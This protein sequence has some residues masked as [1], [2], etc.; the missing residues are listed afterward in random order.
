MLELGDGPATIGHPQCRRV[1]MVMQNLVEDT[2]LCLCTDSVLKQPWGVTYANSLRV[3]NAEL[4]STSAKL[5]ANRDGEMTSNGMA[6]SQLYHTGQLV[7]HPI[8]V[9][10]SI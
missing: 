8:T 10:L 5:F 7:L 9:G 2:G 4:F 1:T 3:S 6:I